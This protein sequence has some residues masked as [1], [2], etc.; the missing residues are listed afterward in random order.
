MWKSKLTLMLIPGA[1]GILKQLRIPVGLIY[2]TI[3]VFLTLVSCR[4]EE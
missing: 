1:T 4:S 3:G 2:L